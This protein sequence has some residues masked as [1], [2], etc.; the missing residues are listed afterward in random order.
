MPIRYWVA[1]QLPKEP[2]VVIP[3][4]VVVISLVTVEKDYS[5]NL[6]GDS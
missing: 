6:T 4:V 1:V 5:P 2:V 3:L